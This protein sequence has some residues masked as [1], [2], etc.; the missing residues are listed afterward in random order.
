MQ[1]AQKDFDVVLLSGH[2]VASSRLLLS[3]DPRVYFGSE[4]DLRMVPLVLL[5]LDLVEVLAH[6]FL[7]GDFGFWLWLGCLRWFLG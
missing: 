3:S 5:V 2:D 7:T 6:L 1:G 4:L